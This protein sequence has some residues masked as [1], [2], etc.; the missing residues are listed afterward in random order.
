MFFRE[1]KKAMDAVLAL[2]EEVDA[3]KSEMVLFKDRI[4]SEMKTLRQDFDNLIAFLENRA[5][6][7]KE[8]ESGDDGELQAKQDNLSAIRNDVGLLKDSMLGIRRWTE[9]AEKEMQTIREE[10]DK[11]RKDIKGRINYALARLKT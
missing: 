10:I 5:A 4:E 1:P 7:D 11:A 6:K 2:K 8:P 3:I 9:N